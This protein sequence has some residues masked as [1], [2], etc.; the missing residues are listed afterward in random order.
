MKKWLNSAA[1]TQWLQVASSSNFLSRTDAREAA[2]FS[3]VDEAQFSR[4]VED[5]VG[6]KTV[7]METAELDYQVTV[8]FTKKAIGNLRAIH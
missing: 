4:V 5:T 2:L 6:N 8:V 3:V 1:G 7:T